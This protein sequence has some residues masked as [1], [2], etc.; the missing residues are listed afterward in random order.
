MVQMARSSPLISVLCRRSRR[1]SAAPTCVI[2]KIAS[3]EL[4][5]T[6]VRLSSALEVEP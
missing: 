4:R 1:V 2:S 6:P 5:T 3:S